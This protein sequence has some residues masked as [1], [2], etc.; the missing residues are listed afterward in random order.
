VMTRISDG[1]PASQKLFRN[2]FVRTSPSLWPK[3]NAV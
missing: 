2:G 3:L 1:T